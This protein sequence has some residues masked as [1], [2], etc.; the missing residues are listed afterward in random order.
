LRIVPSILIRDRVHRMEE[1]T[2]S[3]QSQGEVQSVLGFWQ[4]FDFLNTRTSWDKACEEMREYKTASI[5]GRKRLNDI[6]K[7][8]RSKSRDEQLV[9]FND[10]LKAYQEE[11]DQ[12]SRRSKFCEAAYGNIYKSLYEAPDPVPA[13]NQLINSVAGSTVHTLEIQ[14]LKNELNQYEE[15]FKTLKNQEVTIRQLEAVIEEYKE[16]NEVKIQEEIEKQMILLREQTQQEILEQQSITKSMEKRVQQI[17]EANK[18]LEGKN[19]ALQSELL[20][21]SMTQESKLSHLE[22]EKSI[23]ADG[24]QRLQLQNIALENEVTQLRMKQEVLNGGSLSNS[25]NS[26]LPSHGNLASFRNLE[27]YDQLIGQYK[28]ELTKQQELFLTEKFAMQETIQN[29][30]VQLYSEKEKCKTLSQELAQCPKKADYIALR[31]RLFVVEQIAFH[32]EDAIT[33][34][35]TAAMSSNTTTKAAMDEFGEDIMSPNAPEQT[36]MISLELLL[37]NK[38]KG[39]EKEL[40]DIR[41]VQFESEQSLQQQKDT[42]QYN[43]ELIQKQLNTIH[44]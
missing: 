14:R 1:S 19:T 39:L 17:Q 26:P 7:S 24:I 30:Q 22:N 35:P 29:M 15:E 27:E 31:K 18:V 2:T 44:K 36:T 10:L 12:L 25:G 20:S 43:Q 21:L 32:H 28:E 23:L 34:S 6:T 13:M 37:T 16:N 3:T 42:L 41:K 5:N 11:I 40:V 8:F 9:I 38:I 33:S 4:Q